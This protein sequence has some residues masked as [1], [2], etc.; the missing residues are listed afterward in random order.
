MIPHPVTPQCEDSS[1]LMH[2]YFLMRGID[3]FWCV[4]LVYYKDILLGGHAWEVAKLEDH[5]RLIETTLERPIRSLRSLPVVDIN[6]CEWKIYDLKYVPVAMLHNKDEIWINEEYIRARA[7]MSRIISLFIPELIA[8]KKLSRKDQI[9]IK[10][11][12]S[13]VV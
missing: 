8:G 2:T 9:I 11:V 10:T 13:L 4:G 5:Y 12:W 7:S 3:A 1:I 6:K